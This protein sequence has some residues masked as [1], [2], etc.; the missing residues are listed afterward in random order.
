[1]GDGASWKGQVTGG[2]LLW[3]RRTE[4]HGVLIPLAAC[5][6][7]K[8]PPVQAEN[9]TSQVMTDPAGSRPRA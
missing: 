6:Q 7:S 5:P 3:G 4:A 9:P 8:E 1:M 2:S